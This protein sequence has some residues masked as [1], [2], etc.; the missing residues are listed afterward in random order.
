MHAPSTN[1]TAKR[2]CIGMERIKFI[3]ENCGWD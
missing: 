3:G 1:T 2:A